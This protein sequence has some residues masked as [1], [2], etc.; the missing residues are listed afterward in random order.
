MKRSLLI[1]LVLG[2]LLWEAVLCNFFGSFSSAVPFSDFTHNDEPRLSSFVVGDHAQLLYHFWLFRDML[3][4][5][6]PAF[7]NIYEFNIH[8]DEAAFR[9]DPFYVPFSLV[10]AAISPFFGD[11]AG[12]NSAILFSHILG[13][14]GFFFLTFRHTKSPI[15]ACVFSILSSALPYRWINLI[16]GS[17]T[18]FAMCFV[19]WLF[20]G[21]DRLIR[22]RSPFGGFIAGIAFFFAYC[23]DLHVFA[24]SALSSPF[25]A[26][27]SFLLPPTSPTDEHATFSRSNFRRL[28]L[29]ASPFLFFAIAA[30]L[31]AQANASS[32]GK[33]TLASGRTLSEIKLFSPASRGLFLTERLAGT[34]NSIFVG[35]SVFISFLLGFFAFF[36]TR[37]S[38]RQNGRRIFAV[39]FLTCAIVILFLL[40]FGVYGFQDG[41]ALRA[42]RKLIPKYSMIRQPAKVFCLLPTFATILAS[43][44]FLPLLKA[45]I[46]NQPQIKNRFFRISL[47]VLVSLFGLGIAIEQIRR[48]Y[49]RFC[50]LPPSVPSYERVVSHAHSNGIQTPKAI[51][52]PLWPGDSHFSAAYEY[53]IMHSRLRLLNGYSPAVPAGY[54]E[55]VYKPL[56]SIN[57]GHISPIQFEKLNEFGVHYLLF[58]EF[59]YPAKVSPFPASS[60]LFFLLQNPR[61][62]LVS[63]ENGIAAFQILPSLSSNSVPVSIATIS[64]NL[65]SIYNFPPSFHWSSDRINRSLASAQSHGLS[66]SLDLRFRAPVTLLPELNY[67]ILDPS[68]GWS[69]FA[70]TNPCGDFVSLPPSISNPCYALVANGCLPQSYP[71]SLHFSPPR[72]FHQGSGNFTSDTVSLSTETTPYGLAFH[73]PDLPIHPGRYQLKMHIDGASNDPS[74]LLIKTLD[75]SPNAIYT[76]VKLSDFYEDSFSIEFTHNSL[77]PLSIELHYKGK[78]DLLIRSFELVHLDDTLSSL[79]LP[80][81]FVSPPTNSYPSVTSRSS[82]PNHE[83]PIENLD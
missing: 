82:P 68:S 11:A 54:F 5:N 70:I 22:D 81:H 49:P 60:A 66:N 15:A 38:F 47:L 71:A 35:F 76:S 12:W 42:A 59:P 9:F 64:T 27:L 80:P 48:I 40:S 53:G 23:S 29:A 61:L 10:Y 34:T 2:L 36:S 16:A 20:Y 31:L 74:E 32:L 55:E 18:G 67:F 28:F 26:A 83:S 13:L 6:T 51:A 14:F 25:A 72:M 46:P 78:N 62:S 3:A 4:G 77:F 30:V 44:L 43:L 17:P 45:K 65:P 41:L 33:S 24:F 69:S 8:G 63:H 21:I 56:E 1:T 37:L 19:P 50:I 7:S 79:P 73:G 57:Q 52:I 58:H 75:P 39:F